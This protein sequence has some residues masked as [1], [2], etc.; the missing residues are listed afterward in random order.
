MGNNPRVSRLELILTAFPFLAYLALP[1]MEGLRFNGGALVILPLLVA[2]FI[3]PV[4]GAVNG[5]PRWSLPAL[6]LLLVVLNYMQFGILGV[7]FVLVTATPPLFL[8]E[9]F[10]SG[11][12]YIG[13]IVLTMLIILVT[14]SVK[15]LHPFYQRIRKDWTLLPFALLGI[16]PLA[17]LL[18]FDEY[19]GDVPYQIGIGLILL[20]SVWL[21]LHSARPGRKMLILGIGITLA[22][23]IEAIGKWILIPGQPWVNDIEQTIQGEVTGAVSTWVWVMV[24]VLFPALLGLLPQDKQA[25][26]ATL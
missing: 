1:I 19:Q 8:R 11:F 13:I 7:F 23:A 15:S 20:A 4:V 6:G 22:M 17:I 3:L 16:V 2:L 10:G 12:S 18:S 14:A 21:Y 24:V 25:V 5:M 9:I 26:P